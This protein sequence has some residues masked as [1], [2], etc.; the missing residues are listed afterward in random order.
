M[1]NII[2]RLAEEMMRASF[3]KVLALVLAG[4]C[5]VQVQL[6]PRGDAM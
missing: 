4:Q 3:Y 6:R 1:H 2:Q 5:R